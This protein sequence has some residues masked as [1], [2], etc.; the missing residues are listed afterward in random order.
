MGT[1]VGDGIKFI[2]SMNSPCK[3]V[4]FKGKIL[5]EVSGIF[6]SH[7]DKIIDSLTNRRIFLS[8]TSSLTILSLQKSINTQDTLALPCF[9]N[10]LIW[11]Y[12]DRLEM[13]LDPNNSNP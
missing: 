2:P 7:N 9:Y 1:I 4:N 3:Y 6:L 5:Y 10:T 13:D 11:V 8:S 12:S